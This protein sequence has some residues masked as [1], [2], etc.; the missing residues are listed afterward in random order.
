MQGGKAVPT[1]CN[2]P[3]VR[4]TPLGRREVIGQFDAGAI[5]SD[6]GAIL[7]REVDRRIN[8]L[9]RVNQLIP[10][11]RDPQ[12]LQHDQRTLIAQRVLAIACGWED[13]NDHTNLRNDLVLQLATDRKARGARD[14]V[15]PDRPLASASTLCRLENRI[16]RK[17]CVE[18]NK[19]LVEMFIE[20]HTTAP[21]EVILDFDATDDPVHGKQEGR[22]FH[23][24]YDE[25]CFLPLY[26]FAGEQLLCAYLRPANI[27]GAKHAWAILALIVRRLRAAW[28]GVKIIFRG[29]SGF[30]RWKMLRWADR[31]GVDYVV[32]LAKNPS[33]IRLSAAVMAEAESAFKQTGQKQR[34]FGEFSYAA[35]TWDRERRV[36]ARIEHTDK[37]DDPRFIVTSL[38]ADGQQLYEQIYCARGEMENR[39][40]EQQL[41]LFADRTS[42][43]EFVA[44]QFR[45]LL[46]SL[47]YVLIESLRRTYLAGTELARAQTT[48]IRLRLLKIGAL[49]QRSVRRM[50]VHLSESF[51]MRE[52]F[53]SLATALSG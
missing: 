18:I 50:V 34:L 40:K 5:S 48:T 15:D 17:T 51:P 29:D 6:G 35:G 9:D 21:A 36:I 14:A 41:G 8:L 52:V 32:G 37:G 19:L 1:D 44:N 28:P 13:L 53:Q 31:H 7:L 43:H 46:S 24:Y 39:I 4:F 23:G 42:C 33:L 26:V 3:I 38:E 49:V 20:S 22:F 27:D 16:D 12:H 25:Y 47:A 11:P 2:K 30:C 45:L 10:D